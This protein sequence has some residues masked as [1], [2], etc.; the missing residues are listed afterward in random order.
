MVHRLMQISLFSE[1]ML[2]QRSVR[3]YDVDQSNNK[4]ILLTKISILLEL[5]EY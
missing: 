3:S 2:L 5:D 4:S 1:K